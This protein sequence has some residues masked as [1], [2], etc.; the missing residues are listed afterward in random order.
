MT[1]VFIDVEAQGLAITL[2]DAF[3]DGVPEVVTA[4]VI[5]D[6]MKESGSVY[7]AI[8]EWDLAGDFTINVSYGNTYASWKDSDDAED[9]SEPGD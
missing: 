6:A 2:E 9:S 7:G 4:Q 5:I 1:E 3:P 8:R